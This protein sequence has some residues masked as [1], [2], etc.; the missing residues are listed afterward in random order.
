MLPLQ[1]ALLVA[2]GSGEQTE[3]GT[4]MDLVTVSW[5]SGVFVVANARAARSIDPHVGALKKTEPQQKGDVVLRPSRASP[6]GKAK[7]QVTAQEEKVAQ[8]KWVGGEY[9]PPVSVRERLRFE[10]VVGDV[11]RTS[12]RSVDAY[13]LEPYWSPDGRYVLWLYRNPHI[14]ARIGSGGGPRAQIL[15]VPKV[16]A[17]ARDATIRVAEANGLAVLV[18]APA[19]KERDKTVVYAAAGFEADAKKVAAALGGGATVSVLNWKA[20]A[21]LVIALGT[22]ALEAK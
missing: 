16:L 5:R 6:D 19:L 18:T 17:A 8:G 13:E 1:L 9:T 7:V 2:L 22:A 15:G 10:V 20:D 4:T 3:L 14:G 12:T 11:T 21:E